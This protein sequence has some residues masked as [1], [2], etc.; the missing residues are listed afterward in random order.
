MQRLQRCGLFNLSVLMHIGDANTDTC[1]ET[2]VFF[3]RFQESTLNCGSCTIIENYNTTQPGYNI[4]V[5]LINITGIANGTYFGQARNRWQQVIRSDLTDIPLSQLNY[6]PSHRACIPPTIIDDLYI[7]ALYTNIDGRGT[8]LGS[9]GPVEIRSTDGL[10]IIGEMKF[11]IADI[12][13]LQQKN[14]FQTVILHEM[15]HVLGTYNV[16]NVCA[17]VCVRIGGDGGGGGEVESSLFEY[18]EK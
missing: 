10:P 12:Y 3:P 8:I 16:R 9:A 11:D 18:K 13:N 4:Y 17:C 7:C 5:D 6:R 15:A 14:N 1:I 2:C